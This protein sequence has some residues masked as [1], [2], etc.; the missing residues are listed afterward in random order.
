MAAAL[1]ETCSIFRVL[2]RVRAGALHGSSLSVHPTV[3]SS[4]P[5]LA[6][7]TYPINTSLGLTEWQLSSVSGQRLYDSTFPFANCEPE[8]GER[9]S[10]LSKHEVD[11]RPP[12]CL[13][14]A[15]MA[16]IGPH[17]GR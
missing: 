4:P 12:L 3:G 9:P 2:S 14:G 17:G 11:G 6:G 16:D 5:G 13:V 7:A 10:H 15:L 8:P 1:P